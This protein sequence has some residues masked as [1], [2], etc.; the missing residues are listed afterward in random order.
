MKTHKHIVTTATL[1]IVTGFAALA[2]TPA[3]AAA[4]TVFS[5]GPATDYVTADQP[6][7]HNPNTTATGSGTAGNPYTYTVA[8]NNTS[9]LS[10]ASATDY[11]GP[12]FYGGYTFTSSSIANKAPTTRLI[13]NW[14]NMG[15]NDTIRIYADAGT[16]ND[17][18]NSTLS[19][20]SVYIFK[21]ANF[22]AGNTTGDMALEG[23]SLTYRAYGAEDGVTSAFAPTGRWLVQVGDTYYLSKTT[24]TT[25]TKAAATV[26]LSGA[27]LSGTQW[28]VYA[29][30]TSLNFNQT[31]ASFT[32]LELNKVTAVGIYF[33]QDNYTGTT[34]RNA[35]LL[36]ISAF[37]ATGTTNT[38]PEP[39]TYAMWI[40]SAL[41]LAALALRRRSKSS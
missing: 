9:A 13:N 17:W 31:A 11:A 18:N 36:A 30:G 26:S 35:A 5:F 23:L 8:F 21:Q 24:I 2:T 38:I 12:V 41:A 6:L 7:A 39:T 4:T 1:A 25:S 19:F 28:A 14:A 33:E 37:S 32:T 16:S 34:D 22:T 27:E 40:A 3:N 15:G 20:A 10:P 29:P